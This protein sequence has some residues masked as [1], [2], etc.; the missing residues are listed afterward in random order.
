MY[1]IRSCA[2]VIY[3]VLIEPTERF[4]PSWGWNK[5]HP[6]LCSMHCTLYNVYI[7]LIKRGTKTE[8]TERERER[9]SESESERERERERET[10]RAGREGDQ[11]S[12]LHS[13]TRWQHFPSKGWSPAQMMSPI[14]RYHRDSTYMVPDSG[15]GRAQ[16]G[17]DPEV[18]IGKGVNKSDSMRRTDLMHEGR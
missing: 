13:P 17:P 14:D 16:S 11:K 1:I 10:Q 4:F 7:K 2:V 6:R 3:I 18:N 8:K 5:H 9:E 12:Y 15:V